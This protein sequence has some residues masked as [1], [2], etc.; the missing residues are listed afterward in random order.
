VVQYT[1]PVQIPKLLIRNLFIS[2]QHFSGA[3]NF[4]TEPSDCLQTLTPMLVNFSG[5]I[6]HPVDPVPW[7]LDM[8][9][10]YL[11]EADMQFRERSV[12]VNE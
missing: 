4:M 3:D 9:A 7:A 11:S 6:V 12:E 8:F 1:N 5:K 2:L 10:A